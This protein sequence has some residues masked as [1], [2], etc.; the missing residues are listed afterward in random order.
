[1]GSWITQVHNKAQVVH[2]Q[3]AAARKLA[4]ESGGDLSGLISGYQAILQRIYDDD[5]PLAN[6]MDHADL[7]VHAEGPSASNALPRLNALNWITVTADKQLR[8][9][10]RALFD[11]SDKDSRQF[12]Q[13]IDLRLAGLAKGSLY[14]GFSFEIPPAD[15]FQDIA[16]HPAFVSIRDA[17][18][19]LPMVGDF[20]RDEEIDK[21]IN[22]AIPDPALRDAQ[23]MTAFKMAPTGRIGIHTLE[24]SSPNHKATQLSQR[25]RIV[26]REALRKPKLAN[27]KRG[28][29][30][31]EIR[32]MDLDVQRF[33][34]RNIS[35][36]GA[37]R[38][39]VPM[40]GIE[41]RRFLGEQVRVTGEYEVDKKGRPRLMLV[42]EI[43][44]V[45]RPRQW[46]LE[47]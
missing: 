33:H 37:L 3:I 5:Y 25:E 27:M 17:I 15:M 40:A 41:I 23:L 8:I 31:G 28:T 29:F 6:I 7:V 46:D 11:L 45:P 39:V 4:V 22:E 2:D 35:N 36:L 20:I 42:S 14:A 44:P 43:E 26:I 34:L 1:M 13:T 32:E 47:D 19:N 9:L 30:A 24:I 12:A 10:A 16:E 18:R 38:C 21:E